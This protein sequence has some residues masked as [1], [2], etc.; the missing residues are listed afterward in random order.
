M[1]LLFATAAALGLSASAS[2]SCPYPKTPQAI[3]DGNTAKLEEMLAAKKAVEGYNKDVEGYLTCLDSEHDTAVAAL[4]KDH[5]AL[6]VERKKKLDERKADMD[7]RHTQKH[8]AAVDELEQVA[9]RL[10]EQIR[11]WKTKHPAKTT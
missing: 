11:A 1:K 7:A 9:A 2:A 8:D 6:S 4:T 10:N 3:P 5:A